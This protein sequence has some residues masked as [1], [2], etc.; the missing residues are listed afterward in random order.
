MKQARIDKKMT[1]RELSQKTGI[2]LSRL[3]ELEHGR[4][5]PLSHEVDQIVMALGSK[6]KFVT[7]EEAKK[8]DEE[9]KETMTSIMAVYAEVENRGLGKGNGGSGMM[10]CPKCGNTLA[11]SVAP[12]N[13]HVWGRCETKGCLAW[14][15]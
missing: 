14:M 3:S 2:K 6:I 8:R 9:L 13:G 15:S 11:F 12:I 4:A 1:L 7:S 5:E 10:K